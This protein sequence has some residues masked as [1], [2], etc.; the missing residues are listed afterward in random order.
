MENKLSNGLIQRRFEFNLFATYCFIFYFVPF[1]LILMAGNPL[2]QSFRPRPIY[3]L[4]M[5][6]VVFSMF[7]FWAALKAPRLSIRVP[8]NTLGYLL[9][10]RLASLVLTG[11]FF[12]ISVWSAI[13]LGSDFRHKGAALS[14]LG[15]IG[16][17]LTILKIY[18]STAIIVH[19]RMI[20]E[21]VE[22]NLRAF[23]LFLIGVS[24]VINNQTAV[25]FILAVAAFASCSYEI[26]KKISLSGKWIRRLSVMLLP[27]LVVAVFYLGKA[28]KVGAEEAL[29]L[30]SNF[31][32]FF[33]SFLQRYGYHI[34][35]LSTH[36]NENFFNFALGLQ[37][38]QEVIGV[39]FFRISSIFGLGIER[40][41]LG[42]IARMNF[43]VLADF[44]KDRIG[45][46]PS[47]LGSVFFFPGAGLAIF[48]YVFLLRFIITQFWRIYG[49]YKVPW[50]FSLINVFIL[51]TAVDAALD[52]FNPL[53]NGFIRIFFL[54]MGGNFIMSITG[55]VSKQI[56]GTA[57]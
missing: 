28:N 5:L 42:S 19:H 15:A 48:Y 17:A 49:A 56:Q 25:E 57:R 55:R 8:H 18:A 47:M 10:G 44:Y 29:V 27:V 3:S 20:N 30:I 52:S 32:L 50:V 45:A 34:Y 7:V 11:S 51:A 9:F 1:V 12:A 33:F 46:S 31:D 13:N 37:A 43:F 24:F 21:K 14:E 4:G 39:M 38:I 40:P 2:E 23:L 53:S 35:S 26:R 41:E 16:F 36:V 6:Y 54:V 22:A